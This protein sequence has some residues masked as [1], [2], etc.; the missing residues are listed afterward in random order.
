MFMTQKPT[1]EHKRVEDAKDGTISTNF[2][3]SADYRII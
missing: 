2:L 1:N 3:D